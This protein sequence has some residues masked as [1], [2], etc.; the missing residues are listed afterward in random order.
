MCEKVY[1]SCSNLQPHYKGG[2]R[3][4]ATSE[5]ERFVKL[6]LELEAVNYYHKALNLGCC[7]SPRSASAFIFGNKYPLKIRFLWRKISLIVSTCFIWVC[8]VLFFITNFTNLACKLITGLKLIEISYHTSNS[9]QINKL[10]S[11][12]M[13]LNLVRLM[14]KHLF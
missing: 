8:L 2:S 1:K 12:V 3:A 11:D 13:P 10:K 5:M 9:I 7:S 4:A 14:Y 6:E